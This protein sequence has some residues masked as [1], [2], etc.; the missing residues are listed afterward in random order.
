VAFDR[1]MTM[2]R[3]SPS[4]TLLLDGRILVVQGFGAG[5]RLRTAEIYDPATGEWSATGFASEF[6][7]D[8]QTATLLV[9]GTV[10]VFGGVGNVAELY[11]PVAGTFMTVAP[12]LARQRFGI[13]ARL[14][15]GSVLLAGGGYEEPAPLAFAEL[16]DPTSRS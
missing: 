8:D 14:A 6:R 1:E 15:N 2:W 11:D 9:D 7:A 3:A 10:L 4:I 5:I 13:A 12:P 16:F